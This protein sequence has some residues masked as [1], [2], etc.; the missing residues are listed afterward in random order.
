MHH[1]RPS[2]DVLFT[3]VAKNVGRNALGVLLTGMGADGA[4]G[5]LAMRHK[6]AHTIAEDE[7]TCVVYGMPYEAVKLGAAEH[8]V[9][10]H[11][12]PA[13]IL[14]LMGH[15]KADPVSPPQPA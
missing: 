8:V 5:L 3:S 7:S 13:S 9:P 11:R 14:N 15:P 6:G 12:I 4:H 10:L 2:V 1:Q